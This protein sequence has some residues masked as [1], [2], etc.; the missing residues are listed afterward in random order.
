MLVA[1]LVAL[2]LGTRL[3]ASARQP[4]SVRWWTAGILQLALALSAAYLTAFALLRLMTGTVVS[5]LIL[6]QIPL[7]LA[8]SA[9]TYGLGFCIALEMEDSRSAL[10][11]SLAVLVAY[12][13]IVVGVNQIM[14][15]R[16]PFIWNLL[17]VPPHHNAPD[18]VQGSR[19]FPLLRLASCTLA[20]L[21]FLFAARKGGTH[22]LP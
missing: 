22:V 5:L 13:A 15:V 16:L 7:T 14:T 19:E 3:G 20:A 1:P 18:V 10:G 4:D 12:V 11:L 21:A 6:E 2:W 8:A 17:I 9:V